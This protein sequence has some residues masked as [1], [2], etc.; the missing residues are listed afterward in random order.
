MSFYVPYPVQIQREG[1]K[2]VINQ[3]MDWTWNCSISKTSNPRVPGARAHTGIISLFNDQFLSQ[4]P[5]VYL[6]RLIT[7][8]QSVLCN[9][10]KYLKFYCRK[11]EKWQTSAII[12]KI[13]YSNLE[14]AR[15]V[16]NLESPGYYPGELTGLSINIPRH[17]ILI[18]DL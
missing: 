4:G 8:G 2:S 11:V 5:S 10:A 9:N 16:Q 17:E 6:N 12:W 18:I 7:L 15:Y 14:T 1:E 3:F 13:S